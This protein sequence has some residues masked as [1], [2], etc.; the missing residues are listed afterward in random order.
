MAPSSSPILLRLTTDGWRCWVLELQPIRRAARPIARAQPLRDDAFAAEPTGVLE[1]RHPVVLQ[2][3]VQSH[4]TERLTVYRSKLEPD[5]AEAVDDAL[6][7]AFCTHARNLLEFFFRDPDKNYY[8]AAMDYAKPDY[9]KLD[10]EKNP[11]AKTLYKQLCAQINH[12]TYKR[13]DADNKKILPL[14]R[15]DLIDIIYEQ[16]TRLA[17]KLKSDY[18][19]QHLHLDRLADAA[20]AKI[21]AKGLRPTPE[22]FFIPTETEVTNSTAPSDVGVNILKLLK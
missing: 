6:L 22:R 11:N 7:V 12:L 19:K 10:L 18:D 3:F 2:V 14:Q 8:A 20:A 15:K 16:A 13:T 1:D 9:E 21:E 4:A 5:V 17:R